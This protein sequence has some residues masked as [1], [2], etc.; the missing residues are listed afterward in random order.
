MQYLDAISKTT[1]WSLFVSK[2][3]H[4]ISQL[5]KSMP[6][7]V[8]LK[9]LKLNGSMKTY[10]TF[11]TNTPKRCPFHYRGL[12][13]KSRKS[14]NTWSNRQI[15][16]W[17][18]EWSRAK[19]NRVLPRKRTG[20]SK[21]PLPTTQDSTHGHLQTVNTEI[22]LIIFFV[23]KVGEALYSQQKQDWKLTVARIMSSLLPNS[24][25]NWRNK[26]KPLT[27]QSW[28]K[29]NPLWLYSGSEK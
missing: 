21:H 4:S 13:C 8:M 26:G 9:K 20:H 5:S 17:N 25:S 14:R 24:D 1:E 19:I 15:W 29:S 16:L 22:R 27:I 10:K 18:V 3:D 23:A 7:P 28:P 6:Q 2:A 11:R 12:E